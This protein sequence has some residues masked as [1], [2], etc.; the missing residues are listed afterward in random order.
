MI[1]IN[2]ILYFL[3]IQPTKG[4]LTCIVIASPAREAVPIPQSHSEIKSMNYHPFMGW[5]SISQ[6][7][8]LYFFSI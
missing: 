6:L 2:E 1:K 4:G 7:I 3:A 8:I 5:G